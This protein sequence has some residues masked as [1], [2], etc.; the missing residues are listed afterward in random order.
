MQ[1]IFD[2]AYLNAACN[3]SLNTTDIKYNMFVKRAQ[4]QL[5]EIL[6]HEFYE[7]IESQ[8]PTFVADADNAT[9]YT[10]YIRDYLAWQT[11]F[12]YLK[13]SDAEATPTG[14]REFNDEN[15]SVLSDVK[16]YSFEKNIL[17]FCTT[18][19]NE[20]IN[21]LK[22]SQARDTTKFP[23]WEQPCSDSFS[24]AISAI[25]KRSDSL[26]KVNKSIITNE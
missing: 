3:L 24:F 17:D 2:L 20:L 4:L 6:G 16:K 26:V 25:D 15:S 21:Y 14:I 19:K 13:M 9:L 1:V 11:Y 18:Y 5:K 23:L 10:S 22:L 7:E 12:Y 8:Y